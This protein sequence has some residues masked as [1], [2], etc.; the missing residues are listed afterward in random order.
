LNLIN[1]DTKDYTF[2]VYLIFPKFIWGQKTITYKRTV[3]TTSKINVNLL[4]FK[5][6]TNQEYFIVELSLVL[7]IGFKLINKENE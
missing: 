3:E 4:G 2:E 7:G 1:K 6:T 5:L